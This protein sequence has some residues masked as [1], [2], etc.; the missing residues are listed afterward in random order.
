MG[1]LTEAQIE[2][3]HR[4]GY[5]IVRGMYDTSEM[6][7]ISAWSDALA[8]LPETPGKHMMYFETSKLEPGRRILSRMENFYPYHSG[9]AALFDSDKLCGSVTQLFGEP[10]VLFKE[11]INFKLPGGDG[12]KPHQ[13]VQAGWDRYGSL[14]ISTLISIDTATLENGCLELASGSHKQ[15]V[16]GKMWEPLT[17]ED[18]AGMHFAPCPTQPGDVVFFDSFVAHGSGPNLTGTPRRALYVTYNRRAEGDFRE[19][20]YRDKR[21]SYPPD[22]ERQAGKTYVFRV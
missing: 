22:C 14:H 13:D 5:L 15:G 1:F 12:F 16:V 19:Q 18:M 2:T 17:A 20:Y 7:A 10:T 6:Q 21:L 3:F 11:K 8:A 9:F 4:D